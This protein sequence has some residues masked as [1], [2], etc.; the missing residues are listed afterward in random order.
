MRP[1]N[2]LMLWAATAAFLAVASLSQAASGP[3]VDAPAGSATGALESGVRVFKGLPYAQ[4]PVGA[5]RWTPPKP[6]AKWDGNR[7]ATKF[8]PACVQLRSGPGNIY[9]ND[10]AAMSEDC[11]TLNIWTPANARKA[12][13]LVWIHGGALASGYSHEAI[14]NG[15]KFAQR[16]V[17]VVSIN[18]RLGVLGYLAHPG[19][20]AESPQGISGNYGL[21]DQIEALR[22]VQ[23]NIAAFGGDPS[24]VTIAGES[25]GGLSVMYLM[26]APA[27]RGLFHKAIAES[28]YMISTP[29]LRQARYGAPSAEDA[30]AALGA[31]LKAPDIAALRAMDPEKLTKAAAAARFAPFAAVD[32]QVL[33]RQLVD[34]FDK[35]EQAPVPILTGFNSGEIRSL[36][37]LAPQPPTSAGAYEKTIRDRY[38][39]LADAYLRLYPSTNM[40]NSIVA[41]TRD[42]L[43]GWTS[44]RLV[45]RQT[46]LG[47]PAFL[48]IFDH[49]YQAADAMG[50]HAFHGSELPYVFGTTAR[51][52]PYW[53]KSPPIT[54]ETKLSDAMVDY[55]A[56]FITAG[57]PIAKGQP[58][59]LAFGQRHAFMAFTDAP[60]LGAN[61]LPGMYE[62]HEEAVCRRRA[63]NA[64]WNWN[65]GLWSPPLPAKACG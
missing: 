31:A 14:Y 28:A 65:V 8:G 39:D 40:E 38:L 50:L 25:A 6:L 18:Y 60:H 57:Q 47:Q 56:S 48:Y 37:M 55:W 36:R 11:L 2:R 42:G 22:W 35:G 10:P 44:E 7:D 52:P 26:A 58:D 19:L 59:W 63:G 3:T 62:L 43:Y 16:G 32:G 53:P 34:T 21:L 23:R 20:S 15:A 46:A 29:E 9:A 61:L 54:A 13:V 51:T 12:P 33:P 17:I 45:R 30:G 4:P 49:G 27:A 41:A 5:A 24:N 1:F 64:G